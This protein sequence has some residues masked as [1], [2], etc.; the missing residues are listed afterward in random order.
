MQR[1]EDLFAV[2]I[3]PDMPGNDL[4]AGHDLDTVDVAL[5]CHGLKGERA[6]HTVA[7]AVEASGLILVHLGR[8]ADAR[9]ERVL[10]Q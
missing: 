10:G 3:R 4:V 7:I 1:V 2:P 6:R 5:D 9:I 8:L